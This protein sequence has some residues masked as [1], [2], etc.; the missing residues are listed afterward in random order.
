ML[1]GSLKV[2][3]PYL[4][5]PLACAKGLAVFKLLLSIHIGLLCNV[6]DGTPALHAILLDDDTTVKDPIISKFI[7]FPQV[8]LKTEDFQGDVLKKDKKGAYPLHLVFGA[9]ASMELTC[10][11]IDCYHE[12]I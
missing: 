6:D 9:T 10:Q 11:L 8:V 1:P 4:G 2:E 7:D 12:A 3:H 5:L